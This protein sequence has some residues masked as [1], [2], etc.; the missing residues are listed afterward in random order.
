M[1]LQ[2]EEKYYKAINFYLPKD[3]I[4]LLEKALCNAFILRKMPFGKALFAI[5]CF[6]NVI[7]PFRVL[8]L[9]LRYYACYYFFSQLHKWKKAFILSCPYLEINFYSFLYYQSLWS[10]QTL[11][12]HFDERPAVYRIPLT[13][14]NCWRWTKVKETFDM[15]RLGH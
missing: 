7:T 15:Y 14:K 11:P 4:K 12:L 3:S 1:T 9:F 2:R 10:H 8:T 5:L 6:F 13:L